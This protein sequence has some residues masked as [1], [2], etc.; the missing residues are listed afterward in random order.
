[1]VR[2]RWIG[3]DLLLDPLLVLLLHFLYYLGFIVPV[4]FPGPS[5][6]TRFNT[7]HQDMSRLVWALFHGSDTRIT[8]PSQPQSVA[9][10]VTLVLQGS[11]AFA[12]HFF[13]LT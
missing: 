5:N 9:G 6:G 12:T 4:L 3:V 13:V 7:Q 1:M 11:V 10:I 2:E 8:I